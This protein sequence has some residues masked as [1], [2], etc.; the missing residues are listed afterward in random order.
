[1]RLTLLVDELLG[2]FPPALL[3]PSSDDVVAACP[4]TWR[5]NRVWYFR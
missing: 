4:C 2:V 5:K 1:V 3:L